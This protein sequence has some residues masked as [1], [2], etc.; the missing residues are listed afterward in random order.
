MKAPLSKFALEIL[1]DGEKRALLMDFLT[2]NP[3]KN[4]KNAKQAK[5]L[6]I[7]LN[8][9]IIRIQPTSYNPSR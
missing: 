1:A 4:D 6:E 7:P 2:A 9:K 3:S 5:S 8:G